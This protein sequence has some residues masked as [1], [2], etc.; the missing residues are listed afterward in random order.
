MTS[1]IDYGREKPNKDKNILHFFLKLSLEIILSLF[2]A[3]S[4]FLFLSS[5]FFLFLLYLLCPLFLSEIT[6]PFLKK[7]YFFLTT[8]ENEGKN[9]EWEKLQTRKK[10]EKSQAASF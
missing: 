4:Q 9:T 1:S 10:K 8:G 6:G 5:F 7:H 3:R 2:V